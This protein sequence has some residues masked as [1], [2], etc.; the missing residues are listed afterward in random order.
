VLSVTVQIS[1]RGS[2]FVAT[3]GAWDRP[4]PLSAMRILAISVERERVVA[5]DRG[6]NR[7]R[8]VTYH[9]IVRSLK[10]VAAWTGAA[11]T[12]DLPATSAP[13]LD[14]VAL[15]QAVGESGRGPGAILGAA[16]F[17]A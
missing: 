5:I 3:I 8:T 10:D 17:K 15:V 2:G 16:F 12:V 6:E 14:C 4:D 1:P 9:N 13:G 7:G 11:T